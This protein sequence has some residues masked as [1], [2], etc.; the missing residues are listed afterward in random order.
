MRP[1]EHCSGKSL[2]F[3]L[4]KYLL[5]FVWNVLSSTYALKPISIV[6]SG[7]S[8]NEYIQWLLRNFTLIKKLIFINQSC[9][10]YIYRAS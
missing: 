6:V 7:L 2:T 4:R 5:S 8:E 3:R 10:F 9:T 1:I